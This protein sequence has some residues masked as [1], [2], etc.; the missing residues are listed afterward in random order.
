MNP[1]TSNDD[2]KIAKQP[3]SINR[4]TLRT[5]VAKAWFK[6]LVQV[7]LI[8]LFLIGLKDI[9]IPSEI[10]FVLSL[11]ISTVAYLNY[12]L[13]FFKGKKVT[14]SGIIVLVSVLAVLM[15]YFRFSR[16]SQA[17]YRYQG[18]ML[19][20]NR[21]VGKPHLEYWD[22]MEPL[23]MRLSEQYRQPTGKL[24]AGYRIDGVSVSLRPFK[25]EDGI[26]P[27]LVFRVTCKGFSHQKQREKMEA[28]MDVIETQLPEIEFAE[29]RIWLDTADGSRELTKHNSV[30]PNLT[31]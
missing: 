28:L 19:V 3:G 5:L 22:S 11:L 9:L 7:G 31:E 20:I 8:L 18:Y 30:E 16:E 14:L 13:I 23:L 17:V 15:G 10:Y 6:H 25:T 1:D 26:T 27:G 24:I 29:K 12:K 21:E 4:L 2:P